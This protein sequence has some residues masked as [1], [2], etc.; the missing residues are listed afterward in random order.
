MSERE[1]KNEKESE[2]EKEK[3]KKSAPAGTAVGTEKAKSRKKKIA[4]AAAIAIIIIGLATSLHFLTTSHVSIVTPP[5][6]DVSIRVYSRDAGAETAVLQYDQQVY[7]E[8]SGRFSSSFDG[9]ATITLYL[10]SGGEGR[11]TTTIHVH[12]SFTDVKIG[13]F[14]VTGGPGIYHAAVV[15]STPWYNYSST[16]EWRVEKVTPSILFI[17][18]FNGIEGD[19]RFYYGNT[20]E[21]ASRI[22][23]FASVEGLGNSTVIT[24]LVL[25][26]FTTGARSFL[27]LSYDDLAKVGQ[28]QPPVSA[29]Y[30]D[31]IENENG[32]ETTTTMALKSSNLTA[33]A[34]P[35]TNSSFLY[36]FTWEGCNLTAEVWRIVNGTPMM[37][38]GSETTIKVIRPS[39]SLSPYC[40]ELTICIWQTV[41]DFTD[42]PPL[43][44]AENTSGVRLWNQGVTDVPT[45][46]SSMPAG[47]FY[48]FGWMIEVNALE[49]PFIIQGGVEDPHG[50]VNNGSIQ[51]LRGSGQQIFLFPPAVCIIPAEPAVNTIYDRILIGPE[52]D[53]NS[54]FPT[55]PTWQLVA[56]GEVW[57][58]GGGGAP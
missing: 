57:A 11:A 25:S 22:G 6:L 5:D 38:E 27:S 56:P 20:S 14:T 3:E 29:T 43:I 26:G 23:M 17:Q 58:L 21:D 31:V 4:V 40:T 44:A 28:P 18:S 1:K 52:P 42:T 32:T 9:N 45:D 35:P 39:I 41:P 15:V 24:S 19:V 33:V 49:I 12:N 47:E 34:V 16:Q 37:M 51:Q 53:I 8:V 54:L 30:E 36:Y 10:L 55:T 48:H 13:P 50:L 2:K 46:T 7:F